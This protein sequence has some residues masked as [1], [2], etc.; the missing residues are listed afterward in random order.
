MRPADFLRPNKAR[1][2]VGRAFVRPQNRLK[3][4]AAACAS[5][6]AVEADQTEERRVNA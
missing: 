3:Y 5:G 6:V 4:P 1:R 2:F